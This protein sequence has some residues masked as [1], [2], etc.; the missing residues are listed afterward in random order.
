[1]HYRVGDEIFESPESAVDYCICDDYHEDDDY[2]E[3]WVNE[4]ENSVYIY[5][6]TYYP[7]D[8]LRELGSGSL[9]DL[10]CEYCDAM[11]DDDRDE[12]L[13]QLNNSDPGDEVEC[14]YSTIIVEEDEVPTGD[15]DGDN[16]DVVRK[17]V[18]EQKLLVE[19][20]KTE[21]K[22]TEDDMMELFQVIR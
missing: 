22:K 13:Q 2:F 10:R 17:Y 8:I 21:E 20:Q 14:Q 4:R 11:N 9:D 5:G 7:Y 15:T 16:I 3:E 19:Q 6:T 1:M 18:E 12:A